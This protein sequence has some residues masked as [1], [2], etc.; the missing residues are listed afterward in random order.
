MRYPQPADRAALV[1][2]LLSR[3]ATL[4]GVSSAG[5][6]FGL[7]LTDFRYTISMSTLDGRK[8]ANDEQDARSLQVRV[9]TPAYFRSMAI[10]IVRGRALTDGDRIG[11]PPVVLVNEAA[12]AR[13]WPN[14]NP[15][16][17]EF[18]LGTRMGQ[19]GSPLGGTVVGVA[20]DVHDFGP[21]QAVRPTVY[22]SHAQFPM[23]F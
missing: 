15:L 13:L 11:A 9:V 5:A 16:G 4:P 7:P 18:T 23:G 8:L 22:L 2:S 1:E 20:R 3:A 6:I 17:H 12:A 19:G 14:E 21:L 10:P